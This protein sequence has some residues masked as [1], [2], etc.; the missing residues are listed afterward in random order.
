MDV[1]GLVDEIWDAASEQHAMPDL[2]WLESSSKR[3]FRI[4]PKKTC[5]ISQ[6]T[7]TL[8]SNRT[9]GKQT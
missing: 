9:K 1:Y 4:G 7:S 2:D 8:M 3:V 6:K 5:E